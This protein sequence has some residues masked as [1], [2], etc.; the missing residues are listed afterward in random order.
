VL[1][2]KVFS[3]YA[4]ACPLAALEV[5]NPGLDSIVYNGL[6]DSATSR[7]KRYV[8]MM[9]GELVQ[10]LMPEL[11]AITNSDSGTV[12]GFIGLKEMNHKAGSVCSAV[13]LDYEMF[14]WKYPTTK[15]RMDINTGVKVFAH[16]ASVEGVD[17]FQAEL[18]SGDT[19]YLADSGDEQSFKQ[20]YGKATRLEKTFSKAKHD[21]VNLIVPMFPI[22]YRESWQRKFLPVQAE[23][24][25]QKIRFSDAYSAITVNLGTTKA[26]KK[27]FA[28]F[29]RES[30]EYAN[31]FMFWVQRPGLKYPFLVGVVHV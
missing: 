1:K 12:A 31:E 8:A 19:V 16:Y 9:D 17:V 21:Q 3:I 29:R 5:A 15:V 18:D 22:N 25:G 7:L 6:T 24:A 13:R 4:E 26:S 23:F 2:S 10:G 28:K 27:D 20:L 30:F 11:K 14:K